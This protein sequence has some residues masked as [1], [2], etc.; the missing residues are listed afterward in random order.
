MLNWIAVGLEPIN[1]VY[2]TNEDLY[3]LYVVKQPLRINILNVAYK[4][5]WYEPI[6]TYFP[7][8][9]IMYS[10]PVTVYKQAVLWVHNVEHVWSGSEQSCTFRIK[11]FLGSLYP[12]HLKITGVFD[13]RYRPISM[14]INLHLESYTK[15]WIG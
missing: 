14:Y 10:A 7:H 6:W 5:G 12:S 8:H 9:D 1:T 3:L 15:I 2:K 4:T 13:F 11:N